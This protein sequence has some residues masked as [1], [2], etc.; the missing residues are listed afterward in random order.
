MSPTK[1]P[2]RDIK[3]R[4]PRHN[5]QRIGP[6]FTAHVESL[7]KKQKKR[8]D[9]RQTAYDPT[10][11]FAQAI[12][13]ASE[14]NSLLLTA[15]AD[16]GPQW[17]IGTQQYHVDEHSTLYYDPTPLRE[18]EKESKASAE[19]TEKKEQRPAMPPPE[20]ITAE[21]SPQL[22]RNPSSMSAGSGSMHFS[23]RQPGPYNPQGMGFNNMPRVPPSQFYGNGDHG[24]PSPMRMSGMGMPVGDMGGMGGMP[25][26]GM[27]GMG[28]MG[29]GSPDA[30]RG[31]RRGMSMGEEGYGMGGGM[32]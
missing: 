27:G 2:A 21:V 11:I 6:T 4:V 3:V 13:S 16:R 22:R 7:A 31:L 9:I 23:P 30:R 15:R 29:M 32:H 18:H 28:P 24:M 10:S 25:M 26:G 20:H 8:V 1:T 17:D 14:W 5:S 19:E 12:D